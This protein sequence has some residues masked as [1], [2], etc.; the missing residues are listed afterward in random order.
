V[1]PPRRQP[2]AP[3]RHLGRSSRDLDISCLMANTTTTPLRRWVCA[4]H[5]IWLAACRPS[6]RSPCI[7]GLEAS[8]VRHGVHPQHQSRNHSCMRFE[9]MP[10]R[11]VMAGTNASNLTAQGMSRPGSAN[12]PAYKPTEMGER[13][14]RPLRQQRRP[15]TRCAN[16]ASQVQRTR[17]CKARRKHPRCL[18]ISC[19][20]PVPRKYQAHR[21]MR[22]HNP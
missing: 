22:G 5:E 10:F 13:R 19:Y 2:L 11:P 1:S 16:E 3:P 9:L 4:R 6:V 21:R 14:A 7:V 20:R 8:V 18:E 17:S 12:K 15:R